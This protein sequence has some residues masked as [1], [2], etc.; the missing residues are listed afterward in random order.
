MTNSKQ[1]STCDDILRYFNMGFCSIFNPRIDLGIVEN[2]CLIVLIHFR[3]K[4][5]YAIH[6]LENHIIFQRCY[7]NSVTVSKIHT[8]KV[9]VAI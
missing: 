1:Q 6:F 3:P 7:K 2:T 9:Q 5:N 8:G 4:E